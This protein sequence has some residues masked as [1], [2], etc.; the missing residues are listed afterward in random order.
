MK[1]KRK[2]TH[3]GAVLKHDVIEPLGLSITAAAEQ[4]G[5][6]R[7]ALSELLNERAALSPVMAVRVARATGTAPESWLNM[8]TKLDLWE[9]EQKTPKVKKLKA[10]SA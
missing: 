9:A 4:L 6:T 10:I 3:P 2:P 1:M 8:Q 7:K 5:V